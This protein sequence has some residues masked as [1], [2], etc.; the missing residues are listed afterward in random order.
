MDRIDLTESNIKK[1]EKI[2]RDS[3][4]TYNEPFN[5]SDSRPRNKSMG[6]SREIKINIFQKTQLNTQDVFCLL[7]TSPSPRD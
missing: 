7:Y 1:K 5:I 4:K 2:K 6:G 3:H